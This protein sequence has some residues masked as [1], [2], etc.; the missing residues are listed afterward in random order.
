MI[1]I[2]DYS[3]A[4]ILSMFKNQVLLKVKKK[5]FEFGKTQHH[6]A[7]VELSCMCMQCAHISYM[8]CYENL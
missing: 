8:I 1:I 3:R 2:R 6:F 4:F 7:C 5:H